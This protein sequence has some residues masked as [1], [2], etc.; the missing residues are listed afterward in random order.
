M[1]IPQQ[2]YANRVGIDIPIG[3]N[4]LNTWSQMLKSKQETVNV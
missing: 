3:R 2:I 1:I 4:P